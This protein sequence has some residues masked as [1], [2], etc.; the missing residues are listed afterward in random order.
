MLNCFTQNK[1]Q[2][3]S[4]LL[5]PMN[6]FTTWLP[7]QSQIIQ[8]W[9]R[10]THFKADIGSVSLV[11]NQSGQLATVIC[12]VSDRDYLWDVGHL[13]MLLPQGEY[14]FEE[15]HPLYEQYAIAWGLGA[16]QFTSYKKP[17][18]DSAKLYLSQQISPAVHTIVES[19]YLVRNLI[20]IPTD[21]LGPTEFAKIAETLAAQYH[22]QF[23]QI[24]GEDLLK[25]NYASI[26]TVGRASDDSPRLLDM[27]W[28]ESQH[29][30][31]TLVGK[32][33]CFDS[34]GLDIKPSSAMLLMKKDMGGAAHVLGLARMIMDAKLPL[35]LRVLIPVVEN[36]ISGNAYR[37]G[38]IIKSRKGMTIEIGNT[39]AEGRV[40]L[41]DALAEAVNETPVLLIDM[42]TLTGAARVA[43]GTELPA[44]FSN[45]DSIV[46]DLIAQ[47]AK[48]NDPLWRLPLFDFYREYLNSNIADINNN[49]SEPYG[50]AITAA[51]FLKE[52][53]GDQIPWLHFDM[54]AW[55]L[56]TRPG[57]PQGGE[58]VALRALFNYLIYFAHKHV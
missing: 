35:R 1:S 9:L 19:I 22:A 28:G 25:Q 26:Y 16:Y 52:F 15:S 44:V 17:S 34:G 10:S 33:V 7:Q 36:V 14:R 41:A 23:S 39:D 57:R 51:L 45:R 38:D 27:R 6:T 12:C 55:N 37:P 18:R 8:T 48:L 29:P 58:A 30:L 54:M 20:N 32:G 53:V 24:I 43:L 42:A 4:I 3:I 13:P 40:I 5:V 46:N 11:P 31:I 21:D 50:G 49:S 56:R 47:G 2:V